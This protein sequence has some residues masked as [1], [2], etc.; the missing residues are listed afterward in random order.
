MTYSSWY[1]WAMIILTTLIAILKATSKGK[2]HTRIR[3]PPL[4]SVD[5]MEGEDL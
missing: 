2:R 4:D 3:N 5:D 1:L